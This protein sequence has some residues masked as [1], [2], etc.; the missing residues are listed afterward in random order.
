MTQDDFLLMIMRAALTKKKLHG[1]AVPSEMFRI[2]VDS[3]EKQT[4][5]GLLLSVFMDKKNGVILNKYDAAETFSTLEKIKEQNTIVKEELKVLTLLFQKHN[6]KFI[7]V[8]G[9]TVGELYPE[10]EIRIAGDIDFYLDGENF[11]KAK[12]LLVNEWKIE[13]QTEEDDDDVEQHIA[14]EH[15]NVEF[16]MHFLLL[17][18]GSS[19]VQKAFNTMI[20]TS[21]ECYRE[22]EGVKIPILSPAEELIYTFLHAFHHFIEIGIGLRQICDIAVLIK[23]QLADPNEVKKWLKAMDFEN[24]FRA[25][26]AICVDHLQVDNNI[27]PVPISDKDRKYNSTILD[28]V[29]KRGNFGKYGRKN[30]VRSGISYFAETFFMKTQHYIQFYQLCPTEARSILFKDIPRRIWLALSGR[31]K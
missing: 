21:K 14:F 9:A 2:I 11:E 28:I 17:K 3:A 1:T 30:Q 4:V 20:A 13:F 26:E 5:N 27:L 18:F 23:S 22:I 8:K 25:F 12:D 10:P 31:M 29:F 16:E 6:I 19:K 24:G 15:N 7:V